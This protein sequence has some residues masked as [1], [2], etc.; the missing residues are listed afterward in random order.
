MIALQ[1]TA[2]VSSIEE[3]KNRKFRYQL[4]KYTIEIER[5]TLKLENL[6]VEGASLE[7]TLLERIHQHILRIQDLQDA[8]INTIHAWWNDLNTDFITLNR[9]YQDYIRTLNSAKAEEMMK[10]ESFLIFKSTLLYEL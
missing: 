9:S 5:M 7:P 3:F 8:D 4:S 1:D 2:K 10:T 6:Q